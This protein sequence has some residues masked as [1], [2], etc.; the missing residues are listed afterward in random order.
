[1]SQQN[2][3]IDLLEDIDARQEQLLSEIDALNQRVEQLIEFCT[4]IQLDPSAGATRTS[5]SESS[6]Q[7]SL[8]FD[9][10]RETQSRAA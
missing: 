5:A 1:M 9:A 2:V 6:D 10:S 3:A 7:A 8:S 4:R